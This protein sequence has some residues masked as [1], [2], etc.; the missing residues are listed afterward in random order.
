VKTDGDRMKVEDWFEREMWLS[1]TGN[2]VYFSKKEQKEL[3]HYTAEDIADATFTIIED[4]DSIR[5]H[6]FQVQLRATD[7]IEFAPSQFAAESDDLRARWMKEMARFHSCSNGEKLIASS[8]Q[9]GGYVQQ[10]P[11]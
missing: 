2:L 7:D 9:K 11:V 4:S 5:P 3:V 1:V 8:D 6:T 10:S